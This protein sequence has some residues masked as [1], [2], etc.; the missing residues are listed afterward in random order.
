MRI[1]SFLTDSSLDSQTINTADRQWMLSQKIAKDSYRIGQLYTTEQWPVLDETIAQM[2]SSCD[3]LID[4]HAQIKKYIDDDRFTPSARSEL[5]SLLSRVEPTIELYSQAARSVAQNASLQ[6]DLEMKAQIGRL[7]SIEPKLHRSLKL[8]TNKL[9]G[10]ATPKTS[11]IRSIGWGMFTLLLGVGVGTLLLVVEPGIRANRRA[12]EQ[13]NIH[14]A[15]ADKSEWQLSVQNEAINRASIVLVTDLEGKIVHANDAFCEI[16][17]FTHDEIMGKNCSIVN[18]GYHDREFFKDMF[19]TI[20]SG[21]LWSGNICNRRKDG[22]LYWIETSIVP[23]R[24]ENGEIYQYYS[25]RIDITRQKEAENE[26]QTILN[27][28][29]SMVLYKH[30][31]N[32]ILRANI[33]ASEAIGLDLEDIQ[34]H[35]AD[36]LLM[37]DGSV[38]SYEDDIEVLASGESKMGTIESF[39]SPSGQ[40][41]VMRV[42]KIPLLD[43]SGFFSRIVTI[44][45]DITELIEMEQRLSLA[46]ESARAGVWDWDIQKKTLHTN[47]L[48][49][50]M[51]GD[52]PLPS[53]IRS[54]YFIDR[55]HHDDHDRTIQQ[56]HD[57]VISG[58]RYYDAEYRIRHDDNSYRWIR[59]TG[60]VIETNPNGT[61]SRI[62]GQNLDIDSHKRVEL[63]IRSALE[64]KPG[65]DQTETLTNLCGALNEATQTSFAGVAK[66]FERDGKRMARLIAGS[67]N[68][69]PVDPIEYNLA[70]TP[71]ESAYENQF[72]CISDHVINEFPEDDLLKTMGARGYA[73]LRLTN[74]KGENIGVMMVVGSKPLNSPVDPQ[75]ALKLFGARASVELEHSDTADRLREAADLAESLSQSKSDFLANMSHEIRTPMTAILGYTDLLEDQENSDLSPESRLDAINTIR[76]NGQHLLTIINDI[77]DISKIEAGKMTTELIEVRPLDIIQQVESLMGDRARG[78]GL[79]LNIEFGTQVPEV[80][81]SDPTRLRQVLI[82]LIGNAIKFTESGSITLRLSLSDQSHP[83]MCIEIIDTGIGM[84][85]DQCGS[86]FDA[87]TQADTSTT[88][89]FGGSGLG[90]KISSSLVDILGGHIDVQS[91]LG[92]GSCFRVTIDPGNIAEV[93]RI[94][95][96][97]YRISLSS[98]T[99]IT[100]K[101]ENK[102]QL[103]GMRILLV[104]DGP[105]NQRLISHHLRKA[106]ATVDIAE[107]GRIGV[108]AVLNPSIEDYQLIIMD[109]QMPILDGYGASTELRDR[110][111]TIPIIAL[112]AHAMES[113]RQKCL[114]AGC[115]AF[116]TKPIDKVALIDECFNQIQLAQRLNPPQQ[117][118]A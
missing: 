43:S 109:M 27:A 86:I 98:A 35:N 11:R 44:A 36:E 40:Q 53:P 38:S 107:N 71:C 4:G 116:Q 78:K 76:N 57:A 69:K 115:S 52:S 47:D 66:I 95:L 1:N 96:S 74:S 41:R 85:Q 93:N 104:E 103:D 92:K 82:N 61:A 80:I 89:K 21:E 50:T 118:A 60:K 64:L 55:I 77:L 39:V 67:H 108:D 65:R 94:G 14:A 63:A 9:S 87:F 75:T 117:D 24:D 81:T 73:G 54:G 90:L 20:S 2:L 10:Y 49:F 110:G 56:L 83:L 22:T 34:Q 6:N 84:T 23:L 111:V 46:I 105:D 30:E 37:G 72:C 32:T 48:Y 58:E 100:S 70:G 31:N 17:G 7:S 99:P 33:A 12:I 114:D 19:R 91:E 113:D 101:A 16:S 29:P 5:T 88:R 15:R 13:A 3:E 68:G 18:S 26:L 25:L 102:A 45:T 28:L 8:F 62:I 42:D 97:S 112:T 79:D 106:G 51:L 59:S